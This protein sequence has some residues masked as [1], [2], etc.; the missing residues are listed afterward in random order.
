[1]EDVLDVYE[2]PYNEKKPVVCMD[3]KPYQ[4][5]GEVRWYNKTDGCIYRRIISIVKIK[6]SGSIGY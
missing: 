1:M 3:E 5:L 6:T 4:I 2:L